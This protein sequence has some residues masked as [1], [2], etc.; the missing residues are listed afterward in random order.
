[1][2]VLPAGGVLSVFYWPSV[3][4]CGQK[5]I[6]SRFY[7]KITGQLSSDSLALLAKLAW[8]VVAPAGLVGQPG[9][10]ATCAPRACPLVT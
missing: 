4:H 7:E 10:L 9:G 3:E 8:P 2:P 6:S 5:N 1:M